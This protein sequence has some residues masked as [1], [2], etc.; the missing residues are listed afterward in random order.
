MCVIENI[1][2]IVGNFS[3]GFLKV[4]EHVRIFLKI[5]QKNHTQFRKTK[6]KFFE[7]F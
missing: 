7:R 6:H 4:Q 5:N 3:F 2:K 1:Q